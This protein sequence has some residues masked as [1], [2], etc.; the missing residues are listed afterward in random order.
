MKWFNKQ[1][2]LFQLLLLLVPVVNEVTEWVVRWSCAIEKPTVVHILIAI[3]MIPFG[4]VFGWVYFIW[5]LLFK[6]LIFAA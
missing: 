1:S 5:C 4:V 2:R 6:H 3:L